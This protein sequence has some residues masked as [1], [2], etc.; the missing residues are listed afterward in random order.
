MLAANRF[1]FFASV[2]LFLPYAALADAL[3]SPSS[4]DLWDISQGTVVTASSPLRNTDYDTRDV[5]GGMYTNNTR[6][7]GGII[8]EDGNTAGHIHFLEWKTAQPIILKQFRLF[9]YHEFSRPAN[10]PCPFPDAKYNGFRTFRLYTKNSSGGWDKIYEFS[11]TLVDGRFRENITNTQPYI[12]QPFLYQTDVTPTRGQEFRAEFTQY[13]DPPTPEYYQFFWETGPRVMEMDG[14]GEVVVLPPP[15]PIPPTPTPTPLPPTPTPTPTPTPKPPEPIVLVPGMLASQN[16]KV[17]YEDQSGGTWKFVFGGNIYKGLIQK[18]NQAGFTEGQNLFI[19]HYDWRKPVAEAAQQYLAPMI[20]HAKQVTG[21]DKVDI[22]AHSMGGLVAR[23]YIQGND[24]ANDVDQLVM[25]GT[26]NKGAADAYVAWEGGKFPAGWDFFTR[27]R[28]EKVESA[29]RKSK[30][31]PNIPR[32]LS[33][34]AFFPSLKDILPTTE[35]V[36][37]NGSFLP[38][39]NLTEQNSALAALNSTISQ[40][41]S[42][43]ASFTTFAGKAETTLGTITLDTPRSPEDAALQRWRDGVPNPDPPQPNSTEGDDRVLIS[44]ALVGSNAITIPNTTHFDLPNKAQDQILNILGVAPITQQFTSD[45][46]PTS[47]LGILIL[48]PIDAVIH[49]PD[50][51]ILSKDRNDF[52][53]AVAEYDDDP[54]DPNDPKEITILNPPIGQYTVDY[55]G[56]GTGDYTILTTYDDAD[57]DIST[58][59]TGTTTLGKQE[60][61]SVTVNNETLIVPPVDIVSLATAM[62][63]TIHQLKRDKHITDKGFGPIDGHAGDVEGKSHGYADNVRHH[64]IDSREAKQAWGQLQTAFNQFVAVYKQQSNA[65]QLDTTAIQT[66]S[67]YVQ[68]LEDAGV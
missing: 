55:T 24:Y 57:S 59:R 56:T 10:C 62:H 9:A 20:A 31:F 68:Q 32:P 26:P 1:L 14:F 66:I 44:S 64:G 41:T 3:P 8:F 52:G 45:P 17:L 22:I 13:A 36:Q 30:N 51:K 63:Q 54:N 21:R 28:V 11:P 38:I 25:L 42:K 5:F 35:F 7:R 2:L 43:I 49:S 29:L 53:E 4:D 46:L 27:S 48:S 65:G 34:R 33:F 23:A 39:A 61:F 40:L 50:G 12:G 15:T 18:L 19:A 6:E 67:D 16:K 47:I 37:K 60:S 58:E